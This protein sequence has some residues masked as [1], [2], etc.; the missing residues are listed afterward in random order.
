MSYQHTT[1]RGGINVLLSRQKLVAQE[2]A[3]VFPMPRAALGLDV[4]VLH[5]A[6]VA[7]GAPRFEQVI[8]VTSTVHLLSMRV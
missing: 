5:D 1:I 6:L 4:A 8:V 7:R 3:K 2:A